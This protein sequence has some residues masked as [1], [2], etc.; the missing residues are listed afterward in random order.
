MKKTTI[1]I[2]ILSISLLFLA[3]C[4][5][6]EDLTGEAK[7]TISKTEDGKW[8][9]V[10]LKNNKAQYEIIKTYTQEYNKEKFDMFKR[11]LPNPEQRNHDSTIY[12]KQ[13]VNRK[14]IIITE[15]FE[16]KTALISEKFNNDDTINL[17][18]YNIQ[19]HEILELKIPIDDKINPAKPIEIKIKTPTKEQE[20]VKKEDFV[21]WKRL[22]Q[23]KTP[24]KF[25]Q[26]KQNTRNNRD[27]LIT[28]RTI[29]EENICSHLKQFKSKPSLHTN[30]INDPNRINLVF[31]GFNHE[32][33]EQVTD[34]IN[35]LLDLEGEGIESYYIDSETGEKKEVGK[36]RGIF[37]FS[38]LKS[39]KDKFNFWYIDEVQEAYKLYNEFSNPCKCRDPNI[40]YAEMLNNCG[41]N[42]VKVSILCNDICVSKALYN[43]GHLEL[44]TKHSTQIEFFTQNDEK[45]PLYPGEMQVISH[46]WGHLFGGLAD[47]YTTSTNVDA[48]RYPNCLPDKEIAKELLLDIFPNLEY[49]YGCSYSKDNVRFSEYSLMSWAFTGDSFND[50]SKFYMCYQIFNKFGDVDGE[51]CDS[52]FFKEFEKPLEIC[53]DGIDNN[54]NGK[55][56]CQEYVCRVEDCN[57]FIN[58]YQ[59]QEWVYNQVVST[60]EDF[61][62]YCNDGIDNDFN[63]K[64]DCEDPV[65]FSETC[66]EVCNDGQDN[67][68]NGLFDC[69]D[70]SCEGTLICDE[71]CGDGIDNNNNQ[72]IDFDS[73]EYKKC[74][75]KKIELMNNC[76][77]VQLFDKACTEKG[78]IGDPC[79]TNQ[80]CFWKSSFFEDDSCV[81]GKCKAHPDIYAI[82]PTPK[83]CTFNIDCDEFEKCKEVAYAGTFKSVGCIKN[84]EKY[85]NK[86]VECL[87]SD[88][89]YTEFCN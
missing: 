87:D 27:N 39:N 17:I 52:I 40:D 44:S 65:C 5:M 30:N 82:S 54:G 8:L 28:G 84:V 15:T 9:V 16:S 53:G 29:T 34:P 73:I 48:P 31:I 11:L 6:S 78:G 46:E 70:P 32:S 55:T 80:D 23:Q 83:T 14:E 72:I 50:V 76:S 4:T 58:E 41:I 60:S 38:P 13:F 10:V 3:G 56:D 79:I 86:C 67:N 69:E 25:T 35:Y 77:M 37:Y 24:N 12:V 66:N 45:I 22:F 43:G 26:N 61:Q 33:I 47:E 20:L 88:C 81:N 21:K 62:K 71:I 1:L 2:I 42:N 49:H 75:S 57:E 64:I 51:F 59:I 85:F 89:K 63:K 74:A 36:T 68:L 7:K 18:D 19:E